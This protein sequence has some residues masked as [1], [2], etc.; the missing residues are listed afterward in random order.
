[1][2]VR[3]QIL[4]EIVRRLKA[5]VPAAGERVKAGRSAVLPVGKLPYLL[6]YGRRE[7]AGSISEHGE[8]D[9]RVRR[10]LTV[11]IEILHADPE[12]DDGVADQL[13]VDVEKAMAGDRTLG[14]LVEDTDGPTTLIDARHEGETR[15][16]RARLEF[17][18]QYHTTASRP[19]QHLE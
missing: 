13:A 2:H 15:T 16:G 19:D 8:D 4:L 11:A 9:R 5:G 17:S 3:R 18:V 14:G 1:M 7:E 10:S 12:D 6:V